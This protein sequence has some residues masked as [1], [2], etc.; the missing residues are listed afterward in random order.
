LDKG[1]ITQGKTYGALISLVSETWPHWW[2]AKGAMSLVF[3]HL[4]LK[5]LL[6]SKLRAFSYLQNGFLRTPRRNKV[7]S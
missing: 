4:G 1:Q 3:L 7:N 5:I 2:E 6:K